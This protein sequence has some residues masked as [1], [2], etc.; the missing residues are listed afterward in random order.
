[1]QA[2]FFLPKNGVFGPVEISNKNL[3]F[4]GTWGQCATFFKNRF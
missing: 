2:E 1:M 4:S 3:N